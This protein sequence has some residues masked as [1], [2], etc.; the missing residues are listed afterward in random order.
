MPATLPPF[1]DLPIQ[2][3][4][5]PLNAWGLYG[6]DDEL[7]RLNLIT[8]EA[9]LKGAKAVKHGIAINLNMPLDFP[10]L[11]AERGALEHTINHRKHAND[12]ILTFNTQGSSQWDGFRHYPYQHY[13]EKGQY[14]YYG[15]Q[16]TEEARDK[17]VLRNGTQNFVHHPISSRA[18]LLDIERYINRHNLKPL[19]Y[20]AESSGIPVEYLEDCAKESNV[21]IQ[22]G[23]IL[24][25]RIGYIDA[26]MNLPETERNTLVEREVRAWP[27]VEPSEEMMKWHWEKGIA[28]VVTD[29]VA[30]EKIPFP[31]DKLSLHQVF[32]AGWGLPIGELFDLRKLGEECARLNQYTF[33]FTSMP[34]YVNGGIAS[35]PNAQAI[36]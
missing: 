15:D 9:R 30:Y 33:L 10:K 18:H 17:S 16:T 13:P 19:T 14:R 2:R 5:P 23:D 20:F 36:L 11:H 4:G 21:D 35:P 28:A 8:P 29:G 34:L 22:P 32:L 12:D 6:Q 1:S 26:L 27:G 25:V 24:I 3:P 31:P 7:G